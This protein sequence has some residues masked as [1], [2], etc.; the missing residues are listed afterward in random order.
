M[1]NLSDLVVEPESS[2]ESPASPRTS[3]AWDSRLRDRLSTGSDLPEVPNSK[4]ERRKATRLSEEGEALTAAREDLDLSAQA[5]ERAEELRTFLEQ[6]E[7]STLRAWLLHFDLNNDLRVSPREFSRG[8]EVMRWQRTGGVRAEELF[9]LLDS[10]RSGELTLDEIDAEQ[11]NLWKEFRT[12]TVSTFSS[13]E[14]FFSRLG[15]YESAAQER[16]TKSQFTQGLLALGWTGGDEGVLFAA[17]DKNITGVLCADELKWL[18][19]ETRR[20]AKKD[21]A[22]RRA[23]LEGQRGNVYRNVPVQAV[24]D[25]FKRFLLRKYGNFIRAWR[26]GLSF[27]G[28][29]TLRKPQFLKALSQIGWLKENR[30]L[31]HAFDRDDSE[32]FSFDEL[33]LQSARTL[34]EF[35]KWVDSGFGNVRLAFERLDANRNNRLRLPEFAEAMRKNGWK[36]QVKLLFNGLDWDNKEFIRCED[37]LFIDKWK[38]LPFLLAEP[39]FAAMDEVKAKFLKIYKTFL[40]AWRKLLDKDGTNRCNWDEF[41]YACQHIGFDGDTPGA[42]RALDRDLSGFI[43]LREID[44]DSLQILSDF[45]DWADQEFGSAKS[46]FQVFDVDNSGFLAPREFCHSCRIY[47]YEGNARLLFSALDLERN[48]SVSLTEIYFLDRWKFEMELQEEEED[49]LLERRKA[50]KKAKATSPTSHRSCTRRACDG[51]RRGTAEAGRSGP[52]PSTGWRPWP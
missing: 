34:A 27:D 17:L 13:V 20:Q 16:L 31:W 22:K 2:P 26:Q 33:D 39:N 4:Q 29:M 37:L 30:L 44:P 50:D 28:G 18:E 40:K 3:K 19:V 32:E 6:K 36:S 8:L 35:K 21:A 41:S 7:G 14:N 49:K 45:K 12:W 11:A 52:S 42:W 10:N 48:N 5:E 43:S 47:G 23:V 9:M 51:A 25:M 46:M 38:P 1:V 24:V 15:G